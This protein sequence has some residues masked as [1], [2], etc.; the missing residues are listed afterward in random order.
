MKSPSYYYFDDWS[1]NLDA[2]CA[3]YEFATACVLTRFSPK[4][5]L[6]RLLPRRK[7]ILRQPLSAFRRCLHIPLRT[8]GIGDIV[9]ITETTL[10]HG[11]WARRWEWV[12]DNASFAPCWRLLLQFQARRLEVEP[13]TT[14]DLHLA[15]LKLHTDR[16]SKKNGC[17]WPLVI[18]VRRHTRLV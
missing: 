16:G 3:N 8:L 14:S 2:G 6:S 5:P 1:F 4:I 9:Q 17:Q 12:N 7:G 13:A 10:K 18:A 11:G 15:M